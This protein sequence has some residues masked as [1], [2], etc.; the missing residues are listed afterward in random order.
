MII[1]R[2]TGGLG[3]QMFQ[4]AAGLALAER[5]R[6]VLKLDVSWFR[7]YTEYEAHNRY[8]LSCFNVLEQ[9]A[10]TDEIDRVRGIRLTRTERWSLILAR[11]LR[12]TQYVRRMTTPGANHLTPASVASDFFGQPDH[13][14]LDGM[15]QSERFFAP[16]ANL[17]R[18]HF[19]FRYPAP[20]AVNELA[21]RIR[22]GPSAAVHFRRGDYT[23]NP[24]FT[25][26]IGVLGLDY[27]HR[28]VARLQRGQ[29]DVTL[30][31]FSDDIVWAEREFRPALPHVFARVT[32]PWHAYDK[33]RL[34]CLC[35]HAIISNSTFA[36]WAAWLNPNPHKLVI[37]PDPWLAGQASESADT[38][39]AAWQRL[40]R[41]A[42]SADVGA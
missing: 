19:S 4:Y 23:T 10:S 30:Y 6:T 32:E 17:L 15:W 9:F 25:R 1:T 20:P 16:I 26:Q 41:T 2:L 14:Y 3:N 31:V 29:P 12:L 40:P 21:E 42:S 18:L 28:A 7:E 27:Y 8:A 33:I 39:P 34:M 38:V 24:D 37:A 11:R 36:W 22:R 5:R 13:S 35:D